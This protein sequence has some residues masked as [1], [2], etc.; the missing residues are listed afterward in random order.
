MMSPQNIVKHITLA[1]TK[2][3]SSLHNVICLA[4]IR[5]ILYIITTAKHAILLVNSRSGSDNPARKIL[6]AFSRDF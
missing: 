4:G 6:N 3:N 2:H 5:I 1:S